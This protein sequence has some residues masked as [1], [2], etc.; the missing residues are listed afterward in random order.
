M[1]KTKGEEEMTSWYCQHCVLVNG[2]DCG[3][4][5]EAENY[6]FKVKQ[7]HKDHKGFQ[8]GKPTSLNKTREIE[9]TFTHYFN[10]NVDEWVQSLIADL[11]GPDKVCSLNEKFKVV[12]ET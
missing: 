8:I 10:A 3:P 12:S 1:Q 11:K 4:W 9:L 2:E 6:F 7:A 5:D